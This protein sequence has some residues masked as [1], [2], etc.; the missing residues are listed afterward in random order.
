M[1]G[2]RK[3]LPKIHRIIRTGRMDSW[4]R[5][6]YKPYQE[7]PRVEREISNSVSMI[8][9]RMRWSR[10]IASILPSSI[11]INVVVELKKRCYSTLYKPSPFSYGPIL[12]TPKSNYRAK[13]A[14]PTFLVTLVVVLC[15]TLRPQARVRTIRRIPA[16]CL[17]NRKNGVWPFNLSIRSV[18]NLPMIIIVPRNKWRA[19]TPVRDIPVVTFSLPEQPMRSFKRVNASSLPAILPPHPLLPPH[20]HRHPPTHR[21]PH[22]LLL[23]L[24]RFAL[25]FLT[26]NADINTAADFID[27]KILSRR[28]VA[29]KHVKIPSAVCFTVGE[30]L[31]RRIQTFAWVAR[32]IRITRKITLAS[33]FTL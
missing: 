7:N 25:H 2:R 10:S 9:R 1:P 13:M 8:P 17:R 14:V 29:G 33:T 19:V 32:I 3:I 31:N 18:L 21:Q 11:W 28:R 20:P 27:L 15:F 4:G 6:M 22:L 30:H 5:L 12:N 24:L 16:T 26:Q 23:L